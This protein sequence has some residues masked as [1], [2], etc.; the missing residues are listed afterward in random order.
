[1][2][3]GYLADMSS[4]IDHAMAAKDLK[5]LGVGVLVVGML[6]CMERSTTLTFALTS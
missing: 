3:A 5:L 1:M 2:Q 4:E 6:V